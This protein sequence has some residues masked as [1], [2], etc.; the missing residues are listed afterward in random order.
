VTRPDNPFAASG[1]GAQYHQG[2]PYHHPRSVGR[3]FTMLGIETASRALDVACG[4]G[5]STV[6]LAERV[7]DVVGV[8]R[9]SDMLAFAP[10]SDHVTY[11][12]STAEA[13]PFARSSFDGVTTCSGVHWFDQPRFFAECRR[14]LRA[15]GWVALYD[16]YFLGEMVDVP[17]FAAWTRGLF[18]KYPLPPRTPQVGDPRSEQPAGFIKV[19]DEF[20]ADDIEMTHDGFVDYI[21]SI[22]NL[23]AAAERETPRAELRTE[24]TATT[25]HFFAGT[26]TSVVRFLGSI[27]CLRVA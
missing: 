20:F 26:D 3:I 24:L 15:D 14:V 1:A 12:F 5:M 16:H 6:A 22:S 4:T 25:E 13:L 8:D 2:R 17:E 9:S 21:L 10:R 27:T 11:A 7:D 19:G 18:E 23:V